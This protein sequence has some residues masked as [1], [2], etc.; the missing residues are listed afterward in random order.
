[1]VYY[2]ARYYN[3][4]TGRWISRDPLEEEGGNNLYAFNWND[5]INQVDPTGL[6]TSGTAAEETVAAEEAAG[7][8]MAMSGASQALATYQRVKGAVQTLNMLQRN[9]SNLMD[10]DIS[11]EDLAQALGDI[12]DIFVSKLTGAALGSISKFGGSKLGAASGKVT[13]EKRWQQL[14]KEGKPSKQETDYVNRNGGKG[15]RSTFG[16]DLAHPPKGSAAQGNDYSRA[17]PSYAADHRGIQHR[18]LQ[19]RSTG[20]TI[21][22]TPKPRSGSALDLPPKGALP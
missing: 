2:G 16:K 1:M 12:Q 14:A 20:T 4:A 8:D 19:E 15:M 10:G 9:L 3:P 7:M 5:P 22:L 18:Y 17:N 13:R 21:S 6:Y 11:E